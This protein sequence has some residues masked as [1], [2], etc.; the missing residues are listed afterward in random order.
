[1]DRIPRN[2][3]A[4]KRSLGCETMSTRLMNCTLNRGMTSV[5]DFAH[6]TKADVLR[7]QELGRRTMNELK[8][9]LA[10]RGLAFSGE[11]P[12]SFRERA[13]RGFSDLCDELSEDLASGVELG[14]TLSI[15]GPSGPIVLKTTLHAL[16]K[17]K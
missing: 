8:A 11:R 15:E 17:A 4:I 7:T 6:M 16:E 2:Y 12:L 10:S 13:M 9:I 1:M 3:P 5:W 14:A